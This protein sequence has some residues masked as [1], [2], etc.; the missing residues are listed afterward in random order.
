MNALFDSAALAI[1]AYAE[2]AID[3]FS[4][5]TNSGITTSK[6]GTGTYTLTL[7]ANL[8]QV[9]GRDLT[10][11]QITTPVGVPTT[12]VGSVVTETSNSVKQVQIVDGSTFVDGAFDVLILRTI[13]PPP[14]GAP[15]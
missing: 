9:I 12:A 13:V 15:A 4:T 5:A 6:I 10:I 7:P 2:V 3:G 1:V 8:T 11:V 14:Y